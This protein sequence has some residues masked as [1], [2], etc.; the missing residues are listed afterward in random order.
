MIRD[1][2]WIEVRAKLY[3]LS[4]EY[5]LIKEEIEKIKKRALSERD[6]LLTR[7]IEIQGAIKFMKEALNMAPAPLDKND[8]ETYIIKNKSNVYRE[9]LKKFVLDNLNDNLVAIDLIEKYG[10]NEPDKDR[11]RAIPV[12]W[13]REI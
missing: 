1:E 11:A 13:H 7:G 4:Q 8:V 9:N 2:Q 10:L 12:D 6:T 3:A 5:E